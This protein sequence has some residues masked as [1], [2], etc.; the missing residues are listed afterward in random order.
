MQQWKGLP[1]TS[2]NALAELYQC[3]VSALLNYIRRYVSLRE[4]AEDILIEV[5]L[6]AHEHGDL[7]A[8]REDERLAWLRR[9]AYYKCVDLL[10]RQQR[11]RAVTLETIMDALYEADEHSPE[12][13]AL[14]A[15][16]H[17]LLRAYLAELTVPQQTILHLKFGQRLNGAE[18]ARR[19]NKSES[20]VSKL[21]ARALNQLREMYRTKE[22]RS[23]R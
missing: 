18:I 10:R 8:L 7:L 15:E 22:R 16:E 20:S 11:H 3:Y 2:E 17:S 19:L 1:A 9:V 12:L 13:V 14:R 6:A 5:F 21:L 23:E 4:D